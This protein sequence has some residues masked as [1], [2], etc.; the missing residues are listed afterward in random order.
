MRHAEGFMDGA[1]FV[2]ESYF[3]VFREAFAQ[4]A[5]F[6]LENIELKEKEARLSSSNAELTGA[7]RSKRSGYTIYSLS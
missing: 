6:E 5:R 3:N 7:L 1:A 2:V 4:T